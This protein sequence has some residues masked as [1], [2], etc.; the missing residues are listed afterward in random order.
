[1]ARLGLRNS[2]IYYRTL[3]QSLGGDRRKRA[4][5]V[6]KS[7]MA[8]VLKTVVREPY[9]G[10]ESHPVRHFSLQHAALID[11]LRRTY[12]LRTKRGTDPKPAPTGA[13][14]RE[15]RPPYAAV[16]ARSRAIRCRDEMRSSAW[17]L[18]CL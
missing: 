9:R 8:T 10:F 18:G 17:A 15:L 2:R 14:R 13:G 5:M 4:R 12:F 1:M 7:F 11:D 6:A 16:S 3:G